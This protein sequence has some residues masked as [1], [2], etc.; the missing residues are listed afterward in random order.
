MVSSHCVS[1]S[2]KFLSTLYYKA[3]K[4]VY[5]TMW[6]MFSV[7]NTMLEDGK[8]GQPM[9]IL[10]R[11]KKTEFWNTNRRLP[12][13]HAASHSA[14]SKRIKTELWHH[15]LMG[16]GFLC[17]SII[18]WIFLNC[19]LRIP[20]LRLV[21]KATEEWDNLSDLPWNIRFGILGINF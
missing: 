3:G 11:K 5:S 14:I 19:K 13:V 6:S 17:K 8:N 20:L 7:F 15:W 21:P 9:N 16:R 12:C 2:L 18:C 10:R 4:N 1:K